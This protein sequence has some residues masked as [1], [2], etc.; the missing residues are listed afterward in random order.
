MQSL[1][2]EAN[3]TIRIFAHGW[4]HRW[5]DWWTLITIQ[6]HDMVWQLSDLY[7]VGILEKGALYVIT[8]SD[9]SNQSIQPSYHWVSINHHPLHQNKYILL[10]KLAYKKKFPFAPMLLQR[11]IPALVKRKLESIVFVNVMIFLMS[12]HCILLKNNNQKVLDLK[13]HH[14]LILKEWPFSVHL[15]NVQYLY[16]SIAISFIYFIIEFSFLLLLYIYIIYIV[17]SMCCLGLACCQLWI[18]LLNFIRVHPLKLKFLLA[19]PSVRPNNNNEE[20]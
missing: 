1:S 9:C 15:Y 10:T 18:V 12:L 17:W 14:K 19:C 5:T 2:E 16:I 6:T 11:Q 4:P 8:N 7:F 3:K 13:K 20:L